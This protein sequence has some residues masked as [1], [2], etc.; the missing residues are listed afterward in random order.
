MAESDS[1]RAIFNS[2]PEQLT[3]LMNLDETTP[4]EWNEQ[5]LAAMLCHQM[6]APLNFDLSSVELKTAKAKTR[7][8]TLTSAA[9]QRIKSFKDL[10]F[11]PEPPLDLLRLSKYFF[12][13]RTKTCKKGSPE[14]QVGYLCY[15]LSILAAGSRGAQVS[16]LA[17]GELRRAIRRAL[18][19]KWVDERT[20]QLLSQAFQS[21]V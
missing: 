1:S 11:H 17:P 10:L 14:W 13:R 20:K 12:K 7:D 6:S 5:D 8:E 19:E 18:D 2:S 9:K 15:L 4:D 21:L 16:S 3:K